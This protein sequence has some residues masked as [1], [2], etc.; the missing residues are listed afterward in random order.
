[1]AKNLQWFIE[2]LNVPVIANK[3]ISEILPA[4]ENVRK[5]KTDKRGTVLV[6]QIP[7]LKTVRQICSEFRQQSIDFRAWRRLG[8]DGIAKEYRRP[9]SKEIT[10]VIRPFSKLSSQK[11]KNAVLR[12]KVA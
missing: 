8:E 5:I 10:T 12:I 6:W 1:M 7:N 3:I 11:L 2:Y 4:E 9:S